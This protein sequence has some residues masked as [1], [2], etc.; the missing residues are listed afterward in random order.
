ML[1]FKDIIL[2]NN[3]DAA[4]NNL[5]T[6]KNPVVYCGVLLFTYISIGNR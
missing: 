5:T 2:A 6:L 3:Y 4:Y 1:Y